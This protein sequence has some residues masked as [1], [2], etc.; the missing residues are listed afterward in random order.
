MRGWNLLR[1]SELFALTELL[2]GTGLPKCTQIMLP[3]SMSETIL[4]S[5]SGPPNTSQL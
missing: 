5:P 4:A 2:V 1:N 3:I